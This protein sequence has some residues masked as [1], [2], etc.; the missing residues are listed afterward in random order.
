[1][2]KDKLLKAICSN[3]NAVRF[4]E[5]CKAA[6]YLGFVHHGGKGSHRVFKRRGEPVQMNFQNRHGYIPPYQAR[7]LI[8]MIKKYEGKL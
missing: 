7:Q 3:P 1:M 2:N 5:A 6:E 8:T 4:E